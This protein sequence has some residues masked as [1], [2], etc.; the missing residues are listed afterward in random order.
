ML[1]VSITAVLIDQMSKLWAIGLRGREPMVII[2]NYFDLRYA[3]N[4]GAAF[5]LFANWSPAYRL[6][7]FI[8]ILLLFIML[9]AF[10][11]RT[12]RDDQK[13]VNLSMAL[14]LGGGVAN[15][16]DRI[17]RGYVVDFIRL[18][19]AQ[20]YAWPTFNAADIFIAIGGA[21]FTF[22]II[23]VMRGKAPSPFE[24][25]PGGNKPPLPPTV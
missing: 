8:G 13:V 4:T 11:F 10:F 18:H 25:F 1:S 24:N 12:L 9:M 16:I 20:V 21:I 2:E 6:P 5:S 19:Y 22:H 23:Q 14:L 15:S 3:E 7:F 17:A